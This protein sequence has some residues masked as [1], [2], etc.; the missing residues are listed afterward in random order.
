MKL[1]KLQGFLTAL[2]IAL[3]IGATVVRAADFTVLIEPVEVF[4]SAEAKELGP[5]IRSMVASRVAGQGYAVTTD[6]AAKATALF[7]LRTTVTR[8][9]GMFSIDAELSSTAAGIDGARA[10]ETV[11]DMDSL[12]KGVDK[13][14]ER[15]RYRLWQVSVSRG[16]APGEAN[17]QAPLDRH[18]PPAYQPLPPYATR[19]VETRGAAQDTRAIGDALGVYRE[20]ARIDGEVMSL[21]SADI[22]GDG[23]IEI[24]AIFD[25]ETSIYRETAKGLDQVWSG[26]LDLGFKPLC[27]SAADVDRDRAVEIFFA[28][29]SGSDAITQV[30][31]WR[32]GALVKK[33]DRVNG[34]LRVYDNPERG[35]EALGMISAGGV[36]VFR[37]GLRV[38]TWT[39]S[40]WEA[41][42]KI[43]LPNYV[44]TPNVQWLRFG[45][46]GVSLFVLDR[47]HKLRIYSGSGEKLYVTEKSIQGTRAR[48]EGELRDLRNM[49]PGDIWEI[50]PPAIVW[51]AP[52]GQRYAVLHSNV[53]PS[54]VSNRWG[55]YDNGSLIAVRW[56]GLALHTGGES[57]KFQGFFSATT[58]GAVDAAGR[59]KLYSALVKMEGT[60]FRSYKTT[61]L[62][63]DL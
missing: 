35:A 18:P 8:L 58:R 34:F 39:G 41:G 36:E 27:V 17:M 28:G 37:D 62:S 3:A 46:N 16:A 4:N 24:I 33:G 30:Y 7:S 53:E 32:S 38:Y 61:I 52:D 60:I 56:D 31:T 63:F 5:G 42:A 54:L 45:Q 22:D 29:A 59:G 6:Q 26:E 1:L 9:G 43:Q 13:V 40:E 47:E 23:Q 12:M 57:P 48:I 15:V 51:D 11:P 49:E 2:A 55:I 21:A 20:E 19:P 14:A 50:D 25:R 10:Y 44:N